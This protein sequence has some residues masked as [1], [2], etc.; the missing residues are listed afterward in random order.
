[1]IKI[2][3]LLTDTV[4]QLVTA[5]A[6]YAYV[7]GLRSVCMSVWLTQFFSAPRQTTLES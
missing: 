3:V 6:R 5:T 1:M 4:A 7:L 2:R